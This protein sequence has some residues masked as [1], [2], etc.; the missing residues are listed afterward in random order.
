MKQDKAYRLRLVDEE[1]AT[2]RRARASGNA[3]AA[4]LALER[5]HILAQPYLWPHIRSHTAMLGFAIIQR[6][7]KEAGGQLIRL[8]LA[9]LGNI[10]GRLPRGNTGRADISAFAPM[11]IPPDLAAKIA[12]RGSDGGSR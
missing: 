10:S 5:E 7:R 4:W 8:A 2:F 12:Q 9:P 11:P 1:R 3:E 6:D